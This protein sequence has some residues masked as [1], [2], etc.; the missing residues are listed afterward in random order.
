MKAHWW[1]HSRR[2]AE[3]WAKPRRRITPA[4]AQSQAA[5][6]P[7]EHLRSSWCLLKDKI[8]KEMDRSPRWSTGE[9]KVEQEKESLPDNK[10]NKGKTTVF[11]TG[12]SSSCQW[13]FCCQ[14]K[15]IPSSALT[16]L[17][18][19]EDH[20]ARLAGWT[21]FS[22]LG[23]ILHKYQG[24]IIHQAEKTAFLNISSLCQPHPALHWD[25]TATPL[26]STEGMK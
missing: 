20:K 8:T 2:L 14:R 5:L 22:L 10:T 6:H 26:A 9:K 3:R 16:L 7:D 19:M 11:P 4:K 18:T 23:V 17:S 21:L 13:T 1:Q 24:L 25:G 12:F 15:V